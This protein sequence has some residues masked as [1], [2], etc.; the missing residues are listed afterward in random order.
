MLVLSNFFQLIVCGMIG[1]IICI[2]G[3]QWNGLLAQEI[4]EKEQKSRQENLDIKKDMA[5]NL[6][7]KLLIQKKNFLVMTTCARKKL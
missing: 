1:M 4:V 6:A 5:E 2:Q 7:T 3:S